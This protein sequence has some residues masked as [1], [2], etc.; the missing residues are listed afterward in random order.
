[1]ADSENNIEIQSKQGKIYG[2]GIFSIWIL[3]GIALIVIDQITKLLAVKSNFAESLD[4]FGP[5]V[6]KTNFQNFKFAFSL[7]VPA[8]VMYVVYGIALT[9]VIRHM[10]IFWKNFNF[11]TRAAWVLILCGALSNIGERIALGYVRDFIYI[12]T[13]I[14]N[15]ADG[16][17]LIGVILLLFSY[18]KDI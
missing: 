4:R 7:P 9:L 8:I 13:G 18:Q 1:M 3:C 2:R 12:L 10:V 5:Y 6:G 17:I 16:F 14:F 11:M 15:I